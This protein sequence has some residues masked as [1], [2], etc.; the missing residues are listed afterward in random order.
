MDF[1]FDNLWLLKGVALPIKA[2]TIKL[3]IFK[4]YTDFSNIK[5]IITFLLYPLSF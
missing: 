4:T 1:S 5:Y 2:P 3:Q